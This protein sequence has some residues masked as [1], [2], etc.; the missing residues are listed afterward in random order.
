MTTLQQVT[1]LT[2]DLVR[3]NEELSK[4]DLQRDKLVTRRV[5]LRDAIAEQRLALDGELD[6][7]AGYDTDQIVSPP[8]RAPEAT[9]ALQGRLLNAGMIVAG[10]VV[11]VGVVFALVHPA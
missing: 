3:V 9:L 10:I 11:A 6:A 1:A 7:L 4:L 5:T 8:T 2:N